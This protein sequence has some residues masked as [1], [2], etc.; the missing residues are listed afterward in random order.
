[1][2]TEESST[3]DEGFGR[4]D[5]RFGAPD[6]RRS[7]VGRPAVNWEDIFEIVVCTQSSRKLELQSVTASEDALRR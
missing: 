1:M 6:T 2:R 5:V 3:I 7:D 4:R